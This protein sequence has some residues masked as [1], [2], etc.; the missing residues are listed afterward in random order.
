MLLLQ[1]KIT[2]SFLIFLGIVH[3]FF[4]RYFQWKKELAAI[5]LINRQMMYVHTFFIGVTVALMGLL[6]LLI[7][8]ELISTRLGKYLATGLFAFWL[9]RLAVQFFYYSPDLWRGKRFE[10]T[11]HI[12]FIALWTYLTVLFAQ[13]A[14]A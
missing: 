14:F 1:L 2:G 4:P 5:S 11:I 7:P 8:D 13:I 3:A 6:C 9:L 12:L 10:T